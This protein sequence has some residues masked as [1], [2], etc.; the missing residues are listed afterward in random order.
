[1]SQKT[2]TSARKWLAV[3]VSTKIDGRGLLGIQSEDAATLT[4][5]GSDGTS[6]DFTF[7]AGEIRAIAPVEITNL[8]GSTDVKALYE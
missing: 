4:C 2:Q 7:A 8:G 5:V 6:G 3:T 1:M